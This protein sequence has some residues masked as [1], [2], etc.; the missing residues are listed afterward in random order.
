MWFR[1]EESTF[2]VSGEGIEAKSNEPMRIYAHWFLI[3]KNSIQY[4][5]I[6]IQYCVM[7]YCKKIDT[8]GIMVS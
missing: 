6:L 1:T 3:K 2:L 5:R 7:K 4:C 8:P